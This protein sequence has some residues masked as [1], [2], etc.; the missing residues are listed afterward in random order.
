[1]QPKGLRDSYSAFAFSCPSTLAS[2]SRAS[3]AHYCRDV[4]VV[5]KRGKHDLRENELHSAGHEP[6]PV[7]F[8]HIIVQRQLHVR[9]RPFFSPHVLIPSCPHSVHATKTSRA[10]PT[11]WVAGNTL[12]L[13]RT[14]VT[15]MTTM[16]NSLPTPHYA[17]SSKRWRK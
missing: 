4:Q 9:A 16:T 1:M 12:I 7:L 11:F 5:R 15:P 14:T 2:R 13:E 8:I 17:L 3:T 10:S 6:L